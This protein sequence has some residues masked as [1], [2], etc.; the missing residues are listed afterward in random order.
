MAF[1]SCYGWGGLV[2][3]LY[4]GAALIAT[5]IMIVADDREAIACPAPFSLA[6]IFAA[7]IGIK[8]SLLCLW[9]FMHPFP[10]SLSLGKPVHG[11]SDWP[12]DELVRGPL[13]G[14]APSQLPAGDAPCG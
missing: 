4:I 7:L 1:G 8:P 11:G 3:A 14:N 2:S 9:R 5:I 10:G 13:A 6:L 12:V